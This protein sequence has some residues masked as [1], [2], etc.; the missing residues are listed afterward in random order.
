M[1]NRELHRQHQRITLL[2]KRA[3][4]ASANNLELQAEWARYICI[5][6]SGFLENALKELYSDF[7]NRKASKPLAKFVG[8]QLALLSNP[9][10]DKFSRI[11]GAFS[12]VWQDELDLFMADA[13]RGDAINSIMG[14]RHLIAHGSYNK[15]NI[16]LATIKVYLDKGVEVL[17]FIENQI[18]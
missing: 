4:S 9:K 2:V 5:L 10:T 8:S 16:T 17:E 11:A 12:E 6:C 3:T 1:K 14:Q 15:T 18:Q 7:A 13:G